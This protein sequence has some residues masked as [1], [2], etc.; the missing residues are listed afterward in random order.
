[1]PTNIPKTKGVPDEAQWA[2]VEALAPEVNG[3]DP[4][5]GASLAGRYLLREKLGEGGMGSVWRARQDLIGRDVAV[6]IIHPA[7]VTPALQERFVFE[8][9]VLGRLDHPGIVKIFDAGA[10]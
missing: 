6:K 4:D 9:T 7:L 8:M 1:M 3:L 5:R 10:H 2:R